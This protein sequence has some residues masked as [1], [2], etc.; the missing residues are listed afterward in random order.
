M[1]SATGLSRH[2]EI[3]KHIQR[4]ERLFVKAATA[5]R[6]FSEPFFAIY[7][8]AFLDILGQRP[9]IE[10]GIEEDWPFAHEAGVYCPDE[11]A[12]YITSNLL[13]TDDGLT[14]KVG[15][16][17]RQNNSSWKYEELPT[18]VVMGNG[19]INYNGGI[20]LC[21]Q[22]NKS[23]PGGLILM[24]ARPPY[25][26]TP[27]VSSYHWR[28]FSSVN[29]VVVHTDGSIW[30]TDPTYGF[31]QGFRNEPQLP[32]QV[33]RFDPLSGD[34]RVVADGIG[35]PNGLCF[36]PDEKTMYITDTDWIHGDGSTDLKRSSTV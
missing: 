9:H 24:E 22:G 33:Y 12:V 3:W 34:I 5:R 4:E 7:D 30:F 35:R 16:A 13:K 27:L 8:E 36:A 18:G 2:A 31:E 19:G 15:R 29:D 11:D 10:L 23:E 21:D 26:T 17:S 32:N 25:S 6:P 28:S 20:L 14:I 1:H